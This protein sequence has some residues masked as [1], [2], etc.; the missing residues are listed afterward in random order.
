[1]HVHRIEGVAPC[2]ASNA[3]LTRARCGRTRD[4]DS[5]RTDSPTDAN[6]SWAVAVFPAAALSSKGRGCS[7]T[8]VFRIP[9]ISVAGAYSAERSDPICADPNRRVACP[10]KASFPR[11][12]AGQHRHSLVR[13]GR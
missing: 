9:E 10:P 2:G 11:Q 8:P 6:G 5:R 13:R 7:R 12:L 3:A 4:H 1:V